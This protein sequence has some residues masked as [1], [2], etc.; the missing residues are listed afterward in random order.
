MDDQG[1]SICMMTRLVKKRGLLLNKFQTGNP[2]IFH[3]FSLLRSGTVDDPIVVDGD[4]EYWK[5]VDEHPTM[6]EWVPKEKNNW[7]KVD[8]DETFLQIVACP[9]CGIE[10]YHMYIAQHLLE[11]TRK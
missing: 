10:E 7:D 4:E 9:N 8:L 2:V 11:C 6:D 1:C 3:F 5:N